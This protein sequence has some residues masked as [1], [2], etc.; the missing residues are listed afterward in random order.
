MEQSL[1]WNS[2]LYVN[3]VDYRKAFDS[4]HRDTLWHLLR[5]YGIPLKLTK[6]IKKS[7]ED[8]TCQVVHQ[9]KL[10]EKFGVKTGVCQ[11]CLLSPFLFL[12]AIDWIMK[13]TTEETRNGIQWTLWDQLEDLDFADDLALLSHS[14]QQIQEKTAR[15]KTTSCQVGLDFYPKKTQIMKINTQSIDPVTLDGNRIR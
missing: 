2:S 8:M 3:F 6:L 13:T 12:L 15:L 11:G 7:Y 14:H 1:E 5:H 9:G 4:I 10:T